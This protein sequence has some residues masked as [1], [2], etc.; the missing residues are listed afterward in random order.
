MTLESKPKIVERFTLVACH[1]GYRIRPEGEWRQSPLLRALC[2]ENVKELHRVR[3][4]ALTRV[5]AEL[6]VSAG[7]RGL[8]LEPKG[9]FRTPVLHLSR[10]PHLVPLKDERHPFALLAG[11]YA[12][13]WGIT[14]LYPAHRQA[15][16]AALDSRERFD[17]GEFGAKKEIEFARLR[18][19]VPYGE[20]EL[21]VRCESDDGIAC[22][23]TAFWSAAGGNEACASGEDALGKLGLD[24]SEI[25]EEFRALA[26]ASLIGETNEVRKGTSLPGT[27]SLDEVLKSLESLTEEASQELE[28]RFESMKELARRRLKE[29][30]ARRR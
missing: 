18:R 11:R 8:L 9:R 14:D 30:R 29:L 4:G 15:L 20:V 27:V 6:M 22:A 17:T 25:E 21:S 19:S 28:A 2:D 24:E 10:L 26:E 13:H 23:D 5:V 12:A 1:G 16:Q 3:Q 7:E